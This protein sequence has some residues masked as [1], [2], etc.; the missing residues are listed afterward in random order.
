MKCGPIQLVA[1]ALA[2]LVA[3][4][5]GDWLSFSQTHG[6]AI[7]FSS[8]TYL[9][10]LLVSEQRC[11]P[12]WT[13]VALIVHFVAEGWFDSASLPVALIDSLAH[14]AGALA[15]AWLVHRT[16]GLPYTFNTPRSVLMLAVF[17]AVPAAAI[18]AAAEIVPMVLAGGNA[19]G[20]VWLL[21]W[22][23]YVLG[24]L[25]AAPMVLVLYQGWG[26]KVRI[27][28]WRCA[29]AVV[30]AVI[31]AADVHVIFNSSL[32]VVYLA[33]PPLLWVVLRFGMFGMVQ[34]VALLAVMALYYTGMGLGP[35][36]AANATSEE[37][38]LMVRS[39]LAVLS[40]AALMLQAATVQRRQVQ[41]ELRR[42]RDELETRVITRTAALR[43]SEAKLRQNDERLRALLDA[44]PDQVRLKDV[45]GR[46]IMV[47]RAA[48]EH[49]GRPAA[50]IIG[51]NIFEL[52]PAEAAARI[53]AE[54]KQA[55]TADG[56]IRI[57]RNSYARG[58][59]L[60]IIIAPIR[61]GGGRVSGVVS[62]SRDI[63]ERK[64]AELDAL[65]ESEER[66]RTL[67]EQASDIIYRTDL[68]GCFTYFNT[69][70]VTRMAGY[71]Q[72]DLLGH[73]YLEFVHPDHRQEVETFYRRQFRERSTGSYLEFPAVAKDGRMIWVGQNVQAVIENN[74]VIYHQAVCR[75][76]S[77]RV[78]AQ[79]ALRDSNDKLRRLSARQE[80]LLEAER[81]RIAHDLHDGIGQSLNLARIRVEDAFRNPGGTAFENQ[82]REI[83]QIIDRTT[84]AIRTLEFELSP[85]VL[86][87][88]GLLPALRWLAGEMRRQYGLQV[89]ISDDDEPKPLDQS[90]RAIVF[91]VIRELLINVVRHAKVVHAHVDMQRREDMLIVTV[92]DEGVGFDTTA[93]LRGLGLDSVRER[94][95][96]IG[97]STEIGSTP[98]EGTVT[99]LCVPILA[100]NSG[101][102]TVSPPAVESRPNAVTM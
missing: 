36:A 80:E 50:Q 63:T 9:A 10:V 39:F 14:V 40:V 27:S 25:L 64:Q 53:D 95:S 83:M 93:T 44:I 23:S 37:S 7:A 22:T 82:V 18:S 91:R 77:E 54:D 61:D 15:A 6:A 33:L 3:A 35:Y 47:N 45:Q 2:S 98:G 89:G 1:F 76:I 92:S 16:C 71:S 34:S 70:A 52:R 48:Q 4:A 46:Y 12:R 99:T 58:A 65:R 94:L 88:L 8:G 59:W 17:A 5:F 42:A 100:A 49:L 26:Q 51:K 97:A 19:T 84:A 31:L 79:Q 87:E 57:E 72:Q 86:R 60:E 73:H 74:R 69:D 38:A 56:P 21:S 102:M 55:I 11:W 24:E 29:E 30:L 67:V 32:P 41:E 20:A 85:P 66:Y 13:L 81:T 28:S 62:I 68:H 90:G 78:A 43:E 96:Y 101:Q 75:D